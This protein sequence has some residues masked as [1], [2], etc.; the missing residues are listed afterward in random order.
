MFV[1]YLNG[2]SLLVLEVLLGLSPLVH[3][4]GNG[5]KAGLVRNI[6]ALAP[7]AETGYIAHLVPLLSF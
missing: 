7:Q 5:T 2:N 1:V 4:T 3:P 6:S